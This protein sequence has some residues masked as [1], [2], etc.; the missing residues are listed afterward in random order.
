MWTDS[1]FLLGI[2]WRLRKWQRGRVGLRSCKMYVLFS[3]LK[4]N[5]DASLQLF[6]KKK[7]DSSTA[8]TKGHSGSSKS[9]FKIIHNKRDSVLSEGH[10][11][12]WVGRG[13]AESNKKRDSSSSWRSDAFT[14]NS[15]PTSSASAEQKWEIG[16]FKTSLLCSMIAYPTHNF[17]VNT[18][19]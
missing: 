6:A 7:E 2:R 5:Y 3:F 18:R 10:P 13:R 4:K 11:S 14:I 8:A 1:S 16:P 15:F 12:G 9:Q 17:I 19:M